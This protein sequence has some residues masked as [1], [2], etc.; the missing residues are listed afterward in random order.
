MTHEE[1]VENSSFLLL[2]HLRGRRVSA[3]QLER[4]HRASGTKRIDALI[5]NLCRMTILTR[6]LVAHLL[7]CAELHPAWLGSPI[8]GRSVVL[9]RRDWQL[10]P[11]GSTSFSSPPF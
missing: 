10:S 2:I 9:L 1:E 5:A 11:F 3:R 8:R 4:E 6:M 7:L